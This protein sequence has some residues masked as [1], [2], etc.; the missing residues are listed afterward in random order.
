ML[1][2]QPNQRAQCRI[3]PSVTERT[4]CRPSS[5]SATLKSVGGSQPSILFGHLIV[6]LAL[7]VSEW[8][9]MEARQSCES[10]F[11]ELN[12]GRGR[13]DI[14]HDGRMPSSVACLAGRRR[15]G[16]AHVG[17]ESQ[18]ACS[19]RLRAQRYLTRR[20]AISIVLAVAPGLRRIVFGTLSLVGSLLASVL[21]LTWLIG[22][23]APPKRWW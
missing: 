10:G 4:Y 8:V 16:I 14:C 5:T 11:T 22:P 2:D 13:G 15:S 18:I 3:F 6:L 20:I 17:P 23:R 7:R 19:C 1:D 12:R 9:T 21:F